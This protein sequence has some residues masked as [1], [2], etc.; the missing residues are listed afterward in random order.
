MDK[1]IEEM[2]V[3]QRKILLQFQKGILLYNKSLQQMFIYLKNK[4]SSETLEI[5]YILTRRFNQ[6]ILENFFLYLTM[7]CMGR[8]YDHPTPVQI[9]YRL[10]WYIL[11]K[12]SG[13]VISIRKNTEGNT[14]ES[15]ITMIDVHNPDRVNSEDQIED[16]MLQNLD[17]QVTEEDILIPLRENIINPKEKERENNA[18]EENGEG[19]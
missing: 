15:L 9:Q 12:H 14:C 18:Q 13:H 6:D 8:S 19:K 16:D 17:D 1:F 4:Y 2:R 10:K 5:K 11:G 3:G 7:R